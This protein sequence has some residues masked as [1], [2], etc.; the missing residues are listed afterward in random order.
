MPDVPTTELPQVPYDPDQDGPIIMHYTNTN[1]DINSPSN[2]AGLA[3]LREIEFGPNGESKL[4]EIYGDN[5]KAIVDFVVDNVWIDGDGKVWCYL[6][7]P[8][9]NSGP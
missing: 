7:T 1:N 9:K 3:R 8:M 5:A 4:K 6:D 2:L